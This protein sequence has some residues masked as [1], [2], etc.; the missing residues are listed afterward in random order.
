MNEDLNARY[1]RG[2]LATV[3]KALKARGVKDVRELTLYEPLAPQD[4]DPTPRDSSSED[5]HVASEGAATPASNPELT[6]PAQSVRAVADAD[7]DA[8]EIAADQT[9]EELF[10]SMPWEP[11]GDS[12]NPETMA[13]THSGQREAS[14][15]TA[16]GDAA[17]FLSEMPWDGPGNEARSEEGQH[18]DSNDNSDSDVERFLSDI[19]WDGRDANA[20]RLNMVDKKTEGA[21]SDGLD[22]AQD[23][24]ENLN[25][26]GDGESPE[27]SEDLTDNHASETHFSVDPESDDVPDHVQRVVK[28]REHERVPSATD[29]AVNRSAENG[30]ERKEGGDE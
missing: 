12:E 2:A 11:V 6:T 18:E 21:Q 3:R 13:E 22:D 29:D 7:N 16:D 5:G 15:D 20:E 9:A 19:P 17:D 8:A 4:G 24:F 1:L 30:K 10:S 25:W 27:R 14:S 28:L 23:F 26:E